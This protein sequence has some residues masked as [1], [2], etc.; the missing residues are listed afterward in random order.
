MSDGGRRGGRRRGL[1][2]GP[3]GLLRRWSSGDFGWSAAKEPS[4]PVRADGASPRPR[5]CGSLAFGPCPT[6]RLTRP[7]PSPGRVPRA[8][9]GRLA[10]RGGARERI[11]APQR[12]QAAAREARHRPHRAGHPPRPRGRAAEAARVSGRRPHGR[13]DHRRLHGPD[14]RS[15]G[16]LGR[17]GRCSSRRR[18]TPTPR[19]SRTRRSRCSTASARRCG[20]T[21]SGSTCRWRI[22]SGCCAR[23]TVA[24]L[25]ERDD[26]TKRMRGRASRSRCSSCSTRAPGLRLRGDRGRRRAR[27][28]RPE[29]Q[30]AVRTR[31]AAG[32]RAGAQSVLTMPIL[33]GTDGVRRMSKSLG[34]LRRRHR[35]A[36]GD[37]RQ[38]DESSGPGDGGVLRVAARQELDRRC[39]RSRP[40]ARSAARSWSDFTG[41]TQ[42]GRRKAT[43]TDSTCGPAAR[44]DRGADG[45]G[46]RDDRRQG[47]SAR[48]DRRDFGLCRSEARRQIGQGGVRLDGE[49][50]PPISST[51]RPSAST[52]RSCRWAGASSGAS[53]WELTGRGRPAAGYTAPARSRSACS[54]CAGVSS[55]K[56]RYTCG[57]LQK[58]PEGA[59]GSRQETSTTD[60]RTQRLDS[61]PLAER[62]LFRPEPS[63]GRSRGRSVFEN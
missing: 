10:A 37:V 49:A 17:C 8:K 20:A 29:V 55:G 9:R 15:V 47:P 19:P 26:F 39:P 33:P 4:R 28:H 56:P 45:A 25:F 32:L 16:P 38:A 7:E 51:P 50:L 24:R 48:R 14:R 35:P 60:R 54:P 57:R 2:G 6:R 63:G 58:A 22:S 18:S 43:S 61:G 12:G 40:S 13:P 27:G 1:A 3:G 59:E 53:A 62:P 42:P 46:G 11:A 31:H 30:P 44:G 23:S 5:E 52:A 34:Q 36:R 41:P 21:A